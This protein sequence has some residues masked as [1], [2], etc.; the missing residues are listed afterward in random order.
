MY[1]SSPPVWGFQTISGFWNKPYAVQF[2]MEQMKYKV[3]A[4]TSIVTWNYWYLGKM[5]PNPLASQMRRLRL[6]KTMICMICSRKFG[7]WFRLLRHELGFPNFYVWTLPSVLHCLLLTL[8]LWLFEF[9]IHYIQSIDI[10]AYVLCVRFC[11][12]SSSG[13][14]V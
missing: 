7:W 14:S 6:Q 2:Q 13:I 10:F 12:C 4:L 9:L 11:A 3:E 5:Y 1:W 8:R